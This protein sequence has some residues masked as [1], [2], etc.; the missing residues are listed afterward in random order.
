MPSVSIEVNAIQ[1][2]IFEVKMFEAAIKIGLFGICLKDE[3]RC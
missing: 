1:E 3:R 2:I